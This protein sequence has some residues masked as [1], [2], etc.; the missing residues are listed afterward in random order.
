MYAAGEAGGKVTKRWYK[1]LAEQ[2]GQLA[3]RGGMVTKRRSKQ[4]ARRSGKLAKRG[5]K[6]TKRW[7]KQLVEWWRRLDCIA[8]D[9]A[10]EPFMTTLP[11]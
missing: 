9:P 11:K 1:Q 4:L 7:Y 2:G 10:G 5:G 3:R 6:V 8:G